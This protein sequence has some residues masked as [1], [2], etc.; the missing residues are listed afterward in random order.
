MFGWF[1]KARSLED[2]LCEGYTV[3]VHGV[4]FKLRKLGPLDY[5]SGA[6][7]IRM[8]FD[9]YKT[10]GQKEQAA[11]LQQ[12][13]DKMHEH[14]V[15]VFCAAVMEPKLS[16]KKD[17]PGTIW[18][19]NLFTDWGLVEELYVAIT[20]LTYGKKKLKLYRSLNRSS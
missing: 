16:R 20:T 2:V 4:I 1:R 8:Q 17:E 18:V 10:A 14:L 19:E 3:K 5:A 6:K 7:A 15:D 11:A 13:S 9:T 12:S